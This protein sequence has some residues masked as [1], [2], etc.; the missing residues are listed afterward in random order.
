MLSSALDTDRLAEQYRVDRRIRIPG[1]LD[2]DRA[3]ELRELMLKQVP[4]DYVMAVGGQN[5]TLSQADMSGMERGAQ[6]ELHEQLM[7]EAARGLG[8]LY[9][10][11]MLADGRAR[12]VPGLAPLQALFDFING[13]EMLGFIRAV[14]GEQDIL[15]ADGQATRY[16]AGHFL[17]RHRDDPENEKRRMAYVFSFSDNWHPDWGGLLQFYEEDGTPRDAW[18]PGFNTLSLFDVRHI[19]SVTY[20]TPFAR[21]PRLSLTGWFRNG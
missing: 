13:D 20:V 4:F 2:T 14:T 16:T 15:G 6:R 19:H 9:G 11:Y 1:I 8:F 21:E 5:R 17:T 10:G 18:A 3:R 7:R 12:E